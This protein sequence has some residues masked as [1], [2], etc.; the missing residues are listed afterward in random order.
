MFTY[1]KLI[2]ELEF[3]ERSKSWLARKIDISPTL[4]TLMMQSKRTFQ[5]PYKNRICKVLQ[6]TR[7]ELF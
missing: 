2:K 7:T 4:L 1:K 3:Q 6:K 5:E